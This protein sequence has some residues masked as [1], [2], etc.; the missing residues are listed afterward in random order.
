[1]ESG[2]NEFT[3][4][5]LERLSSNGIK[6]VVEDGRITKGIIEKGE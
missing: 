3:I 4:E 2:F 6:F 1:M 5:Q